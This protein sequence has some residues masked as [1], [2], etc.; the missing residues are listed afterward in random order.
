MKKNIINKISKKFRLSEWAANERVRLLTDDLGF[1]LEEVDKLSENHFQIFTSFS[2][3]ILD[4]LKILTNQLNFSND[5]LKKFITQTPHFPDIYNSIYTIQEKIEIMKNLGV[6]IDLL[7]DNFEI[8]KKSKEELELRTKLAFINNLP[9][10][11]YICNGHF[12]NCSIIWS[13]M[14]AVKK[15]VCS[16]DRIYN[17]YEFNKN[18]KYSIGQLIE[19]FP[20]TNE[21]KT[22]IDTMYQEAKKSGQKWAQDYKSVEVEQ[23]PSIDQ[24]YFIANRSQSERQNIL[25]QRAIRFADNSFSSNK[26]FLSRYE[27][28]QKFSDYFNISHK[29]ATEILK[30]YPEV[31]EI[32]FLKFKHLKDTIQADYNLSDE[33]ILNVFLAKPSILEKSINEYLSYKTFLKD[34]LILNDDQIK[35]I[36]INKPSILTLNPQIIVENAHALKS[37]FKLP[38]SHITKEILYSPQI[39]TYPTNQLVENS[40][41]FIR[42]GVPKP[43]LLSHLSALRVEQDQLALKLILSR[44]NQSSDNEFLTTNY[45]LDTQTA[46]ART[47][48]NFE[49]DLCLPVYVNEKQYLIALK[50]ALKS[51]KKQLNINLENIKE[52][53]LNKYPLTELDIEAIINL[54]NS[55]Y[56]NNAQNIEDEQGEENEAR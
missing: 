47:M 37:L 45:Q 49:N 20:L 51:E 33:Q 28:V 1:S 16:Y 52:Y 35:H 15:G 8:F 23:Q 12:I 41:T 24:N 25:L 19:M 17:N 3:D 46:F 2:S 39:F 10:E 31:F 44:I 38:L 4:S 26:G 34:F 30:S 11:T 53:L 55:S 21:T 7:A 56:K 43:L 48:F 32:N 54:Y 14:Q 42:F 18:S 40:K 9:L 5:V 13:R 22:L 50:N 27:T 29:K 6:S 36:L